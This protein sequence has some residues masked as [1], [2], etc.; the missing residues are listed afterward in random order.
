MP[1]CYM[2]PSPTIDQIR[3]EGEKNY[4]FRKWL[5][6]TDKREC[7]DVEIL[8][9]ASSDK[10]FPSSLNILQGFAPKLEA[11]AKIMNEETSLF[12]K[13]RYAVIQILLMLQ[14]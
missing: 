1:K 11:I 7:Y 8:E 6:D 4:S 13:V 12:F 10:A 2:C 5:S 14:Q 3:A 9:N